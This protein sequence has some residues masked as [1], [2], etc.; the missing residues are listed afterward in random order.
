[1]MPQGKNHQATNALLLTKVVL[2]CH[3]CQTKLCHSSYSTYF[4]CINAIKWADRS[5]H[6]LIQLGLS[7][8]WTSA[9]VWIIV[10]HLFGCSISGGATSE[11]SALDIFLICPLIYSWR[12]STALFRLQQTVIL[13]LLTAHNYLS[14]PEDA[15]RGESLQH[16]SHT[17]LCLLL[18]LKLCLILLHVHFQRGRPSLKQ[19]LLHFCPNGHL[20]RF[21]T[22]LNE[23]FHLWNSNFNKAY[24]L[25]DFL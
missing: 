10:T 14:T 18:I 6:V 3:T 7:I 20:F 25:F 22:L 9:I 15:Y 8:D 11:V 2:E 16:F 24:I 19:N 12:S 23:G 13:A 17:T 4:L 21:D 1:M 5:L